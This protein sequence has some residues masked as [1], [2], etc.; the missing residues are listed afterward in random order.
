LP[1]HLSNI[2]SAPLGRCQPATLRRA[3]EPLCSRQPTTRW[4]PPNLSD[5]CQR[6]SLIETRSPL[7]L[8]E[9]EFCTTLDSNL[10][11]LMKVRS[12]NCQLYQPTSLRCGFAVDWSPRRFHSERLA[13]NNAHVDLEI[14]PYHPDFRLHL[15]VVPANLSTR[16]ISHS[17]LARS[18]RLAG[19]RCE[20]EEVE[21]NASISPRTSAGKSE[22]RADLIALV[23]ACQTDGS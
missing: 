22:E 18:E 11:K 14:G 5:F 1:A 20:T 17:E 16:P 2:A 21:P 3:L 9:R 12:Q 10:G 23:S 13:G 7:S 19:S 4:S 6:T 15:I 8:A